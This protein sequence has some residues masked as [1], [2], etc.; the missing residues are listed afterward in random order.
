[1]SDPYE[2]IARANKAHRLANQ[3]QA[4]QCD[5]DTAATMSDGVWKQAEQLANVKPAS[6]E[7]R[8][9]VVR[10]LRERE[11]AFQKGSLRG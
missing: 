5:A 8:A 9:L 10:I 11:E 1:M 7:T 2:A 3:L 6:D 4:A